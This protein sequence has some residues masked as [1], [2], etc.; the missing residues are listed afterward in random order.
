MGVS[1][2]MRP[3]YDGDY[4][5]N[6]LLGILLDIETHLKVS[7]LTLVSKPSPG[8]GVEV[9]IHTGRHTEL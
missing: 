3:C 2:A 5:S 9:L 6:F 4:Y 8:E 1:V 7:M